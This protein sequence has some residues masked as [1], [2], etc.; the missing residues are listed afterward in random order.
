WS[1]D[2]CSS[3]LCVKLLPWRKLRYN[4]LR[5]GARKERYPA[6]ERET[7]GVIFRRIES[8]G[9]NAVAS[10]S[11]YSVP[12]TVPEGSGMRKLFPPVLVQRSQRSP[13]IRVQLPVWKI[14]CPKMPVEPC[15]P[16]ATLLA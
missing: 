16:P 12:V 7:F 1:S 13:A 15:F 2:V 4:S 6:S 10:R 8:R 14:S 11:G 5:V 3:D 9:L